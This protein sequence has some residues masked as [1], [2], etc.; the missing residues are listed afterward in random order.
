M[1]IFRTL[2]KY[3]SWLIPSKTYRTK[4]KNYLTSLDLKQNLIK[5]KNNYKC[6]IEKLKNKK[7][8]IKVV[9]LI[10]ENQ[11]WKYQS[12]YD[13]LA[14]SNCFEPLILVSILTLAHKGKDKTRNNLQENYKFFKSRGMNVDYAYKD[15]KYINLKEFNPDIVFY[16]QPWDLPKIHRPEYIS[17]FALTMY[18]PYYY[19]ILDNNEGYFADFHKLLHTYFVEHNLNTQKYEKISTNN[20][21]NCVVT[22]Y[23]KF[24]IYFQKKDFH[25]DLWKEKDKIKIIYAP[26]HSIEKKGIQLATFKQN[27]KFILELAKKYPQTTWIFKPHPRLKY[28]ILRNKLMNE[29]ELE[30]YYNEWL[31][32]GNIYEQG[33]Y[34]DMIMTSDLMITDC[35]SFLAEYL[36]TQNPLIRLENQN[37]VKLTDLGNKII[38]SYYSVNNNDDLE[39][40]FKQLI[41]YNNDEKKIYRYDIINEILDKKEQSSTKIYKYL[42]NLLEISS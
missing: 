14:Q 13:E 42:I 6:V 41:I 15:R 35:C 29:K 30:C 5:V 33:D 24:D 38:K 23:P 40:I 36:F 28:A 37:S 20:S 8:K 21:K 12:V 1:K 3:T 18:S 2:S 27:G 31:N 19:D 4:Y 22:G 39:K 10:R 34:T 7:D 16:D 11:K 17:K 9:F 25:C 26:H 32:I